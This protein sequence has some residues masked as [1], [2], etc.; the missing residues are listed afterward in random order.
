MESF[1]YKACEVLFF[2]LMI[3]KVKAERAEHCIDTH[4]SCFV[5][6]FKCPQLAY[7][8]KCIMATFNVHKYFFCEINTLKKNFMA[9]FYGWGSTASRLEPL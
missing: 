7:L 9:S 2:A 8:L 1:S 4:P 5:L 6:E 3:K